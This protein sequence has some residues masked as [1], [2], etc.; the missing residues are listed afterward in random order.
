MCGLPGCEFSCP[1]SVQTSSLGVGEQ[2]SSIRLDGKKYCF[3]IGRGCDSNIRT[4]YLQSKGGTKRRIV[5]KHFASRLRL[6]D[7]CALLGGFFPMSLDVVAHVSWSKSMTYKEICSHIMRMYLRAEPICSSPFSLGLCA[8]VGVWSFL[9][10]IFLL[11][12]AQAPSVA[13]LPSI[14][15]CEEVASRSERQC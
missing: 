5:C 14:S 9:E 10:N 7:L 3:V 13:L 6:R 15:R 2:Y 1:C 8:A 4:I 11:P 12:G